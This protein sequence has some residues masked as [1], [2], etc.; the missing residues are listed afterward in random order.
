VA[1]QR[2]LKLSTQHRPAEWLSADLGPCSA[3]FSV[4]LIAAGDAE[5]QGTTR[6]LAD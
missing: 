2:P 1:A 5:V 4:F 3:S 6:V